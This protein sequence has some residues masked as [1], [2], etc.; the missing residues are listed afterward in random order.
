MKQDIGRAYDKNENIFDRYMFVAE[1][2]CIT[3]IYIKQA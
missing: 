2:V 3:T 1:C